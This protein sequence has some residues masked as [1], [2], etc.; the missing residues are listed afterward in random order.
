MSD[1][2]SA[3]LQQAYMLVEAGQAEEARH[4]IESVLESEQANPDAWWIYAHA[5]DDPVRAR[6]ALNE[7]LA[8]D[9]DYPGAAQLVATLDEQYPEAAE[10]ALQATPI[11]LQLAW[12][13]RGEKPLAEGIWDS[14]PTEA[15]A[16][17]EIAGEE[18]SFVSR[19]PKAT[20]T[21]PPPERRGTP[22]L[23]IATIAAALILI[24][25]IIV[26]LTRPE[27]ADVPAGDN[28]AVAGAPTLDATL[29][30]SAFTEEA[31]ATT[32]VLPLKNLTA[33]A[34]EPADSGLVATS[35]PMLP[36]PSLEVATLA[37]EVVTL[38][39]APPEQTEVVLAEPTALPTGEP[40][41]P[42]SESTLDVLPF[43]DLN[44]L[45]LALAA[46]S[47]PPESALTTEMTPLGESLVASFC[48]DDGPQLRD[49]TRQVMDTVTAEAPQLSQST[50]GVGVRAMNCATGQTLRL[51]VVNRE[52]ATLFAQGEID[53]EGFESFWLS[54]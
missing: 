31:T 19:V 45:Q 35:E 9:P 44:A 20:V 4:L 24:L 41:A 11:L 23:L 48:T 3:V 36:M 37:V 16:E 7:V 33:E 50:G 25:V 27:A 13:G 30:A 52:A 1:S 18:P 43:E 10:T 26:L 38:T 6:Q 8:L 15:P 42:V 51:I 17:P 2:N 29:P 47:A 39:P 49:L 34:T 22:W 32:E 40:S 14:E 54:L 5:V 12:D 21:L 28:T 46:F 53:R